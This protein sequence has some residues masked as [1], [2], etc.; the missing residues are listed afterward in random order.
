MEKTELIRFV[1]GLLGRPWKLGAQGPE[2]F[3]CWSLLR[4]VE[5]QA[6]GR[7]LPLVAL[8]ENT[9]PDRVAAALAGHPKRSLWRQVPRP[10]HG[11]GV[12]MT[13]VRTPLHVGVWLELDGGLVL[14]C[15]AG[16]GVSLDSMLALRAMGWN[17]I[18][19][20]DFVGDPLDPTGAAAAARAEA[21]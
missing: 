16:V 19:Y 2:A 11:G 5:A 21:A 18:K 12:E 6:F 15:A 9:R 20:Y 1:E 13:S 14:H 3:D 4:H 8:P 7:D 10:S 17:G